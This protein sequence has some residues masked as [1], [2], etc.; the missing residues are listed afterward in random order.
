M[1]SDHNNR[2]TEMTIHYNNFKKAYLINEHGVTVREGGPA[3]VL[4]TDSNV[5]TLKKIFYLGSISSTCL[6]RVFTRAGP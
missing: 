1:Q 3:N 4:T 6:S 2:L 5:E